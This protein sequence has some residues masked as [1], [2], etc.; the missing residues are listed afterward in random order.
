MKKYLLFVGLVHVCI[1]LLSQNAW[2]NELHYDDSGS[3]SDEVVEVVIENPSAYDL[4]DFKVYLYNGNTGATYNSESIDNFNTGS[5]TGNFTS[6]YWFPSSIQNGAPDGLALTYN[7]TLV[8]G[9]FLSYEGTFTGTSGPATDSTSVDMG[10]SESGSPEG[11]SLQLSGSGIQYS[12]FSWLPPD[13]NTVGAVN[14]SQ[15]LQSGSGSNASDIIL[16]AGWSEPENINFL[17]FL[18]DSNLST[19]NAIEVASFTIRDGGGASDSDTLNTMVERISFSIQSFENLEVVALFSDTTNLVEVCEMDSTLLFSNLSIEA[20][21]DSSTSFSVYA[22]FGSTVTDNEQLQFVVQSADANPSGSTFG[23][24][25]GG[26]AE[27]G[28]EGDK[29]RLEVTADRL[30]VVVQDTVI[31]NSPF[32]TVVKATDSLL[33]T[34]IDQTNPVSLDT[35]FGTLGIYSPSGLTQNLV[36]GYFEWTDLHYDTTGW[37]ALKATSMSLIDAESDSIW[38]SAHQDYKLLLSKLCDPLFN[39]ATDR[40]IQIYNAGKEPI[41]LSAWKVVAYGNGNEIFSWALSGTIKPGESKTCGDDE[42]TRFLPDFQLAEWSSSNSSWNGGS[43]DGANLYFDT[44]LIDHAAAH[45]N[46][47]NKVSVRNPENTTPNN[48]FNSS[49]WTSTAVDFADD[50][51]AISGNH[52]CEAPHFMI[53]SSGNWSSVFQAYGPGASYTLSGSIVVDNSVADPATAFNIEL[54][55]T[56]VIQIG[57]GKALTI[58]NDLTI[59]NSSRSEPAVAIGGDENGNGSL[60]VMG[61]APTQEIIMQRHIAAYTGDDDGWHLISSPLE[62]MVISNSDFEPGTDD[63]LYQWDEPGNFWDNYKDG[64]WSGDQFQIGKGYL[65]AFVSDATRE[66]SGSISNAD[67]AFDDLSISTSQG[68]GWHLLGNPFTSAIGWGNGDWNLKNVENAAH[69]WSESAGNYL[70]VT[71]GEIIPSTNGFFVKVTDPDNSITIPALARIHD[72][73]NNYKSS[74]YLVNRET[75]QI[76]IQ[77]LENNFWDRTIVG[78]TD[79]ASV[80]YNPDQDVHKLFGSEKAPQLWTA[81]DGDHFARNHLAYSLDPIAVPLYFN[82]GISGDFELWVSGIDSFWGNSSIYL[83]DKYAGMVFDLNEVNRFYFQ[84]DEDDDPDR[85]V[86]HFLGLT[87]NGQHSEHSQQAVTVQ[88]GQIQL[89]LDDHPKVS[90]RFEIVNL[91]GQVVFKTSYLQRGLNLFNP[92]LKSGIYIYRYTQGQTLSTGKILIH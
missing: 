69:V 89:I 85:F 8:S 53:D 52:L 4:S 65:V 46:F 28:V 18:A 37:F 84:A 40:Y 72:N 14:R 77:N 64:G 81:I 78:F 82:S 23:A 83:E 71:D 68:E 30:T 59:N 74:Q 5:T 56:A 38:S 48:V 62:S 87:N 86:L 15:V 20:P 33:N 49:E 25:D 76:R 44:I 17:L 31:N 9:Q 21:D 43:N 55:P 35:L 79:S 16:T 36:D 32:E 24:P 58:Y 29:N 2:I 34:D 27:T 6:Y 39:Y 61:E 12:D 47:G 3:D 66:F 13:T 51:A 60:I 41:D 57:S 80:G 92:S 90:S 42:N 7:D 1:G 26:G 70:L 91:S 67:L 11:F 22:T 45:G 50:P 75:L 54:E 88:N 63:D 10:V 19:Q 73:Q